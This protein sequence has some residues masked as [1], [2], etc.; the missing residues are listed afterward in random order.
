MGLPVLIMDL[1]GVLIMALRVLIMDLRVHIMD[2]RVLIMDRPVLIMDLQDQVLA[3]LQMV[4]VIEVR[5]HQEYKVKD[6]LQ[7]RIMVHQVQD[8]QPIQKGYKGC[9][10]K[11]QP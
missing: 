10:T 3:Q 8:R 4:T 7:V 2:H 6:R 9:L 1:L 11:M 5:R